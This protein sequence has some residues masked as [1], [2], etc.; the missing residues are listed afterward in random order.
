MTNITIG[1]YDGPEQTVSEH[2]AGWIEGTRPDGTRWIVFLD[3]DGAPEVYWP[4]RDTE[5]GAV[6]GE[7]VVLT[8]AE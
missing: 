8:A 3:A 7:A 4:R 1:R 2:C 6:I 5:T